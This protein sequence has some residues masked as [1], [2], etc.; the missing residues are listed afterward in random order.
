ME[1]TE[2]IF[3]IIIAIAYIILSLTLKIPLYAHLMFGSILLG[4]LF[5]VLLLKLQ[6]KY[7][8]E[9]ISKIFKIIAII[10]I[11]YYFI[12]LT[13]EAFYQNPLIIPS[14]MIMI[15]VFITLI[16]KWIFSAKNEKD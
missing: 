10:L 6:Q 2:I 5:I 9:K 7:K 8:N 16:I 12:A 11:I 1:K 4:V 14:G 3:T 15:L 13:Y